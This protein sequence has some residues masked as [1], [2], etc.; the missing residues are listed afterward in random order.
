VLFRV[1]TQQVVV[2]CYRRF[3]T[4]FRSHLLGLRINFRFL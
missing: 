1:I 4:T 2:I 3:G